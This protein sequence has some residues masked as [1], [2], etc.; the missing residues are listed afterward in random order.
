MATWRDDDGSSVDRDEALRVWAE[1]ARRCL[2]ELARQYHATITYS[3]LADLLQER[4]GIRTDQLF[5]GWINRVLYVT[6][7]LKESP[8]EPELTA[9]VVYASGGGVGDGFGNVLDDEGQ[10][11]SLDDR[12]ARERLRCYQHWEAPDLPD[13]GGVPA[14][15]PAVAA[16]RAR[17][18]ERLRRAAPPP[19]CPRCGEWKPL[20]AELC[21]DCA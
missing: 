19:R 16:R 12:A 9:L 17:Q 11:E 10:S 1:T 2:I 21:D 8:D 18:A 20:A 4:S 14:P 6:S 3:D 13:D 5:R 15:S 7:E